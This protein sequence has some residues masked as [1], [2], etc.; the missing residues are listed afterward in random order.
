[1]KV[2]EYMACGIPVVCSRFP[3]LSEQMG[4]EEMV[5]VDGDDPSDYAEAI[6]GLLSH[7]EKLSEVGRLGME[8][9][10][11]RVNWEKQEAPKLVSMYRSLL[12]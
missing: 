9:V 3:E 7:P 6:L 5:F 4:E 2:Y 1:M 10:R 11:T 8:A 12:A